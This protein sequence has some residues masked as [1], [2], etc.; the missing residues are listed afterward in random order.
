M[1]VIQGALRYLFYAASSFGEITNIH[2]PPLIITIGTDKSE[3]MQSDQQSYCTCMQIYI[4]I[5]FSSGMST[6]TLGVGQNY[7][8]RI[9]QQISVY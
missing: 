6:W 7:Q 8:D 3:F 5:V 4:N 2:F 1:A 9:T